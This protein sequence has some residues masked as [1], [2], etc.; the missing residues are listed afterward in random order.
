I[1]WHGL[2]LGPP[3]APQNSVVVVGKG[4]VTGVHP[5]S[6]TVVDDTCYVAV[7]DSAFSI[8]LPSLKLNWQR[9]VDF[10]TCFGVFW[11]KKH[12][13]LI[14]HG[15]LD[16]CRW[17]PDGE[18]VWGV[19]GPE[20]FTGSIQVS[21]DNLVVEDFDGRRFRINMSDGSTEPIAP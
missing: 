8:Q 5:D 7:G 3:D 15:E 6:A 17:T 20:I 2:V 1:C 9:R 18:K 21:D 10:A 4:G 12:A 14:T 19:S 11:A 13:C 16:I